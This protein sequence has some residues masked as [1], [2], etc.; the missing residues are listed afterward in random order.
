MVPLLILG[1]LIKKAYERGLRLRASILGTTFIHELLLVVFPIWYSVFTKYYLEHEMIIQPHPSDLLVVI[2]GE[3]IFVTLFAIGLQIGQRHILQYKRVLILSNNRE[4]L[5]LFLLIGAGFLIYLN[6]FI[7]PPKTFEEFIVHFKV[8]QYSGFKAMLY[9]WFKGFFQISSIVASA[10]VLVNSKKRYPLVLRIMAFSVLALVS[11]TSLSQG[12]RGRVVIVASFLGMAGFIKRRMVAFYVGLV[13]IVAIV[14]LFVFLGGPF[15]SIYF[16]KAGQGATRIELLNSITNAVGKAIKTGGSYKL[17]KYSFISIFA[18]RAQASRNSIVLYQLYN[19][20][21]G[22]GLRP[23]GAAFVSPIPRIIWPEKGIAG[24]SDLTPTGAAVYLVRHVG[25]GSP[26]YNVGPYLASAHAYWE[27]GWIWLICAGFITGL[28]WN[29]ILKWCLKTGREINIIIAL[30]LT[31]GVLANGFLTALQPLFD[32]V[33]LFWA[34]IL[35]TI[36][37]SVIVDLILTIKKGAL[38]SVPRMQSNLD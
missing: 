28:M 14:P 38:M 29:V 19:D 18:R 16:A 17:S 3:V 13:L 12:I 34:T 32:F 33:R 35:P 2:I 21:L 11:L 20:G 36:M 5:F 24:S 7:S 4:P 15:R 23:L 8:H 22:A 31:R 25:Y 9:A 27:G 10:L 37:L 26:V 1:S 6:L 30:T